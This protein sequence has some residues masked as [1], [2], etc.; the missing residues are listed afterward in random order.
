MVDRQ[1]EKDLKWF[2]T[3]R[4]L[5]S[6][7]QFYLMVKNSLLQKVNK[8]NKKSKQDSKRK[9][10]GFGVSNILANNL[11]LKSKEKIN[12]ELKDQDEKQNKMD[13]IDKKEHSVEESHGH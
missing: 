7:N 11:S 12:K 10:T 6:Q 13:K 2:L 4:Q 8:T 3:T 9:G 5:Q 1:I